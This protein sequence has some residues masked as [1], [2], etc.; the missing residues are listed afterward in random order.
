MVDVS[1][2]LPLSLPPAAIPMDLRVDPQ[3]VAPPQAPAAP[4]DAC[5]REQQLQHELLAL[6]HRQQI[7]RQLLI[8]EFQRQHEQLSRQHEAQ[9]Q[10]HI[11]HQQEL[12]ALKHQQELLEHQRKLERHRREQE[13]EKQQREEK[14]RQLKN[15][16]RGQESAVAST[17]VKMRLQEFVL[18]KKK[19]LAQRS[20]N[21]C[22]PSDPRYWYGTSVRSEAREQKQRGGVCGAS[23]SS[24]CSSART[25]ASLFSRLRYCPDAHRSRSRHAQ[26]DG[27]AGQSEA[28]HPLQAEVCT[29]LNTSLTNGRATSEEVFGFGTLKQQDIRDGLLR[30]SGVK[31]QHSSLD[32][33]SPPQTGMSTYNNPV[34]GLYDTKDD[35]PL[36]KTGSMPLGS[37]AGNVRFL[38]QDRLDK[39]RPASLP[40]TLIPVADPCTSAPP[41]PSL[42]W[43]DGGCEGAGGVEGW[44]RETAQTRPTL[45][46]YV[47]HPGALHLL[48]AW[49]SGLESSG[50]LHAGRHPAPGTAEWVCGP[51]LGGTEG[52]T[53]SDL[54]RSEEYRDFVSLFLR[55]SGSPAVTP[56]S[57][58]VTHAGEGEEGG[59][60]SQRPCVGLFIR[61]CVPELRKHRGRGRENTAPV[62]WLTPGS[63][64]CHFQW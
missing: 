22:M 10:E 32:Q 27:E 53:L 64:G 20:L 52:L 29:A 6:K 19:A 40:L 31:T 45:R 8:A 4:A 59:E 57:P 9:L 60:A 2:A 21:H 38:F 51:E 23:R 24:A 12:L 48:E 63:Q 28:G 35:F 16:E 43:V 34:L 18:N 50:S 39:T 55:R 33:S 49:A 46:K 26:G 42:V 61:W 25:S 58:R 37:T 36:R 7:Q 5:Q 62:C 3:H 54:P 17:E 56:L 1:A 14:L 41:C 15:K 44:R 11:K 13:L 30:I 47:E